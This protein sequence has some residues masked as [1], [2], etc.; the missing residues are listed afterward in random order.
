[1][2]FIFLIDLFKR[3]PF[4]VAKDFSIRLG[5][6]IL[7]SV[8][9]HY[10]TPVEEPRTNDVYKLLVNRIIGAENRLLKNARILPVNKRFKTLRRQLTHTANEL[11][12]KQYLQR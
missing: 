3:L 1:M 11:E 12:Q 8:K 9:E 4:G 7:N 5:V 2:I 6:F 10:Q